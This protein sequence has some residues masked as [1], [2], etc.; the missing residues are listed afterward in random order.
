MHVPYQQRKFAKLDKA[1]TAIL[2][3]YSELQ[4]LLDECNSTNQLTEAFWMYIAS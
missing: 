2:E 3:A 4:M 1:A